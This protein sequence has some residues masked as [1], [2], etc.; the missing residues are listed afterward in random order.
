VGRWRAA[1]AAALVA[2]AFVA[3][4][5]F[6]QRQHAAA[7]ERGHRAELRHHLQSMRSAIARYRNDTG[8]Y[9]KSLNELV[10]KYLPAIPRDPFTGSAETWRVTTEEVVAPNADFTKSTATAESYVIDVHSGAP[11]P[12][13]NE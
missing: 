2:V 3:A 5:Q 8:R 4:M 10:P 7:D 13:S 11:A 9:P 6:Y 1:G 12:Y